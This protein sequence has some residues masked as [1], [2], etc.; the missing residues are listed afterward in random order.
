MSG[1]LDVVIY[2]GEINSR[3]Y[4][5]VCNVLQNKKSESA[6]LVLA[7][8]GGNPRQDSESP[9]RFS[10]RTENLTPLFPDTA[11]ALEH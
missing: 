11:K 7:T 2:S 6:L 1:D 9:E 8:P 5:A 10:I 4:D 3:G